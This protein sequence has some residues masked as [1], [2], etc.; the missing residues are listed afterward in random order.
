MGLEHT[1]GEGWSAW[2]NHS[3]ITSPHQ[4][5]A[6]HIV[7]GTMFTQ[8][9]ANAQVCVNQLYAALHVWPTCSEAASAHLF[10]HAAQGA[11]VVPVVGWRQTT[12]VRHGGQR[13]SL[14][15]QQQQQHCHYD[16]TAYNNKIEVSVI[17]NKV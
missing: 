14:Q 5:T 3:I 17:K 7:Q 11:H 1:A 8:L 16:T 10:K 9:R 2:L 6:M 12:A 4:A 13:F 15:Q